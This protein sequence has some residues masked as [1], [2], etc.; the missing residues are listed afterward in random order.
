V[1]TVSIDEKTAAV[2]PIAEQKHYT[3][4]I[5]FVSAAALD[6]MV[7]MEGVPRTW[8]ID[9]TGTVRFEAIGYG[10]SLSSNQIL[11]RLGAVK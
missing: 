11:Q 9:S 1:L 10:P 7:G 6:K 4:P 3:F 2:R 5:V 8:I